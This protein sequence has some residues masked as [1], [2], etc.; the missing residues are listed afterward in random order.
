V[1]WVLLKA[2]TQALERRAVCRRRFPRG[3]QQSMRRR[4]GRTVH[5]IRT[6]RVLL[7][8]IGCMPSSPRLHPAGV[9]HPRE[10]GAFGLKVPEPAWDRRRRRQ[11]EVG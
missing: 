8:L 11:R 1:T 10:R 5:R 4:P 2:A 9:Y 6:Y 3:H 7:S